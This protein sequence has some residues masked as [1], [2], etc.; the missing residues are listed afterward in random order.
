MVVWAL[1]MQSGLSSESIERWVVDDGSRLWMRN[2]LV[3]NSAIGSAR[4]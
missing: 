3:A 1:Q 2:F 4:M